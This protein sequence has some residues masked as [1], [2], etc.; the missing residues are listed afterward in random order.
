MKYDTNIKCHSN[1]NHLAFSMSVTV[2]YQGY[3]LETWRH[4]SFLYSQLKCHQSTP[5]LTLHSSLTH[6]FMFNS[7]FREMYYMLLFNIYR[8]KL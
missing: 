3:M 5:I 7:H 6:T 1:N 4:V 8:Y 2:G